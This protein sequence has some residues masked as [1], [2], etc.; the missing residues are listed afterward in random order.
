MQ[1]TPSEN[2]NTELNV[3]ESLKIAFYAVYAIRECK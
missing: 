1:Y 3:I 2:V